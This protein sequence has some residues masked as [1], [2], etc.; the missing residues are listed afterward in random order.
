LDHGHRPC[1]EDTT[2]PELAEGDRFARQEPAL[3]VGKR[4]GARSRT[5]VERPVTA[6]IDR[7]PKD[8]QEE[9]R[10]HTDRERAVALGLVIAIGVASL[11]IQV[12]FIP[13]DWPTSWDEAVYLSQ[14]T[15]GME[16]LFFNAWHARGITLIVAPVTWLGGS[17]SDVRLLLM[18]LSA[19]GIT[20]TF[21]LWVP[22]V[23]IAAAVAAF[24]FSFSWLGLIPASEIKPNYLGALLGLA[25]T[26]LVARRLEDDRTRDLVLAS[27]VLAAM[28][29]VRPTEATVLA[30]AIGVYVLLFRR[31]SWR[32]LLPLG[33]G[34]F[35]GWLPWLIEMSVRFGGLTG[36]LREAG[37][38]HHFGLVPIAENVLLHLR[39]T[40]G[41][42]GDAA[43][44]GAIW[45][46]VLALMVAVAIARGATRADRAAAL[47]C[48]FG[49]L[50]LALEYLFFVPALTYRFLLPAYAMAS[51]PFAIGLVSLLRGRIASRVIGAV[52]L[53]LMIPW[54][55][56]QGS[57]TAEQA[58]KVNRGSAFPLRVGAGIRRLAEGRPCVV[59]SQR[60][61]PQVAFAAGCWGGPAAF[62]L[63]S[64]E[65]LEELSRGGRVVFV[66][67]IK[68]VP[69]D[70]VLGS[71]EPV[72]FPAEF[73]SWHVYEVPPSLD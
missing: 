11:V 33:V 48:A 22:V 56:W 9:S 70:S 34:L 19:I 65:Y 39:Y 18:V 15:P 5:D 25:T 72:R 27:I 43:T 73:S 7:E 54:A 63:L 42:Y 49:A 71:I 68:K 40:D 29:L 24:V 55:I 6:T 36:A 53:L 59:L 58:P 51:V 67:R 64:A 37:K 35:L 21:R 2:V 50:A 62:R 38:E 26:G 61:Y 28:A 17:V 32:D 66:V 8:R 20:L 23:G 57:V 10:G 12:L 30:G 4:T 45:W 46:G 1:L 52:V 47:L 14:V 3:H 31:T 16:G 60:A 13:R 44:P 41:K 69:K